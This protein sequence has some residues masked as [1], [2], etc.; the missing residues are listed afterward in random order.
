MSDQNNRQ[1]HP[2]R[3]LPVR[4]N[5]D[6][7]KHQAKDLLRAIRRGEP[8]AIEEFKA[9]HPK[10]IPVEEEG[11]VSASV[12]GETPAVS[13][14]A[15]PVETAVV[16]ERVKLADAQLA[17]ARSYEAQSWARLV[18]CCKLIDAIWRDDIDAVREL[19]VK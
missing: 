14:D 13:V 10:P 17:L 6:Q 18:Q 1:D 12:A 4:P 3:R 11:R 15:V 5:L 19:V 2:T 7:L 9:F 8:K 16:S